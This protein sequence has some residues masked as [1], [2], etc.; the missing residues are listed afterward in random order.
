VGR[1]LRGVVRVGG[2]SVPF[3]PVSALGQAEWRFDRKG[4]IELRQLSERSGGGER[5][6]LATIWDAPR[7]S[8]SRSL[9]I[10]LLIAFLVALIAEALRT[11]FGTE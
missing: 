5:L 1:Q 10:Y 9:Q 2:A 3:G 6:D 7:T 8:A 11:R 4:P